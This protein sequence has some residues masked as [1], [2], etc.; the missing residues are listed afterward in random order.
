MADERPRQRQR[1]LNN[2]CQSGIG[3]DRAVKCYDSQM[4]LSR[5]GAKQQDIARF[6]RRPSYPAETTA[7]KKGRYS[8]VMFAAQLIFLR[9]IKGRTAKCQRFGNHTDTVQPRVRITPAK[10]ERNTDKL[11]RA[12]GNAAPGLNWHRDNGSKGHCPANRA[13]REN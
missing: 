3:V 11:D 8:D 12:L 1:G 7:I 10:P 2:A 5:R 9:H 6:R 4:G 13:R